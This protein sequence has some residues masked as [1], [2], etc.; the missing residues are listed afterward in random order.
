MKFKIREGFLA[1]VVEIIDLGEGR[2]QPQTQTFYPGKPV[3]L[4]AQQAREHAHKLEPVD[5]EAKD[6]LVSLHVA[7]PESGVQVDIDAIVAEK[8]AAAQADVDAL[9]AAKVAA[10]LAAAGIKPAAA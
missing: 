6:F 10:A 4:T 5:K 9:V 7:P 1:Q 8:V 2:T 3:E